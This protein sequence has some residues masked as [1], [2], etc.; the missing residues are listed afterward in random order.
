MSEKICIGKIVGV[1]GVKGWLKVHSF[2]SPPE[3]MLRYAN[4]ELVRE[5]A[6]RSCAK[7]RS[8]KSQ[9]KGI[10][11]ALADVDDR[12]LAMS[13]VGSQI[14]IEVSELP[15]L[16]EGEYYWRQLEGLTVFT[17][18]GVNIGRVSHLIETGAND[19]LVVT[20]YAE[21]IDKRERLIPYLPGQ[22]IENIDL[23][24]NLMVVDWD[25]DF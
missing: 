16:E 3:N 5:D 21:S 23:D 25:P 18:E 7:L 19:V 9:G 2:T 22:F 1:Y 15:V 6:S 10:V 8:G 12:D 24:K 13:Y 20:G 11:I 4:W 14:E 17:S